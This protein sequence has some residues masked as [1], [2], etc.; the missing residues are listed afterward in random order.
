MS[1]IQILSP[2]LPFGQP[3]AHAAAARN[4]RAPQRISTPLDEKLYFFASVEPGG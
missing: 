1:G 4:Y 3:G 2:F